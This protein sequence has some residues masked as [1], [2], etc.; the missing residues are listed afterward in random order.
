MQDKL[1]ESDFKLIKL[2]KQENPTEQ[3]FIDFWCDRCAMEEKYFNLYY[4]IEQM[5]EVLYKCGKFNPYFMLR[6]YQQ[7]DDIEMVPPLF[8]SNERRKWFDF[9]L[10]EISILMVCDVEGYSEWRDKN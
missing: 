3:D 8:T 7:L 2:C 9:Y 1:D 10:N 6:M 5:V 4:V